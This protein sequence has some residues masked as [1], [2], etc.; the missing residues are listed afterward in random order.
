MIYIRLATPNDPELLNLLMKRVAQETDNLLF[1]LD[2]VP[3]AAQLSNRISGAAQSGNCA[4]MIASYHS[5]DVGYAALFRGA[6]R[7][8]RGVGSLA[9]AV[10][11]EFQRRGVG[12]ALIAKIIQWA[13]ENQFYRIQLLVDVENLHAIRLYQSFSFEMEG[14]CRRSAFVDGR[15]IDKYQMAL[16]L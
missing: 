1:E 3:S 12:K 10:I 14:T 16:L 6:F 15:Y 4:Y 7:R 2:E 9:L 5:V 8:N 11:E 13:K